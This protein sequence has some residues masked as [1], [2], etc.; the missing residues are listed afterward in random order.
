MFRHGL[1]VSEAC[2]LDWKALEVD[3]AAR[4]PAVPETSRE[5]P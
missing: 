4:P 2:A 5:A 1:R 3:P